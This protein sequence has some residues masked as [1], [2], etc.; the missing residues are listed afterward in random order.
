MVIN[1]PHD[2][3]D[4][5]KELVSQTTVTPLSSESEFD[6]DNFDAQTFSTLV[7]VVE[8]DSQGIG[9]ASTTIGLVSSRKSRELWRDVHTERTN[10]N[11]HNTSKK[12][13][14]MKS[15]SNSGM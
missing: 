5:K 4:V 14:N 13:L 3:N 7:K 8:A 9:C 10:M 2:D 12:K 1:L 15:R 6:L 11:G